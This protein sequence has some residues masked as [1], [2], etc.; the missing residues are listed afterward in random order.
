MLLSLEVVCNEMNVH[1]NLKTFLLLRF[2]LLH[3]QSTP[4]VREH[5]D[6]LEN[7]AVVVY[8]RG[9]P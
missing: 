9:I 3:P 4:T 8:K 1:N 2:R 7:D 6:G 5:K